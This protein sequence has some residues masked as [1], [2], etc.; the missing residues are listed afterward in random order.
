MIRGSQTRTGAGESTLNTRSRSIILR[1]IE[2]FSFHSLK[3]EPFNIGIELML[4]VILPGLDKLT[5]NMKI[6]LIISQT[7]T[8]KTNNNNFNLIT[9][10]YKMSVFH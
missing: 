9:S 4:K 5:E 3:F 10:H 7:L 6:N 8:L 1:T 2:R